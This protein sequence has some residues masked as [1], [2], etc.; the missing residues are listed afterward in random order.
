MHAVKAWCFAD[1]EEVHRAYENGVVELHAK[2]R[3]RIKEYPFD[4][5]VR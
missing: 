2:I 3:A 1:V 4:E 5:K